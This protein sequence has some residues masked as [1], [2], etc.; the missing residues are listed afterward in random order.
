MAAVFQRRDGRELE[1]DESLVV[2]IHDAE[3][4]QQE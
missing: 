3:E 1:E 2:K 4:D